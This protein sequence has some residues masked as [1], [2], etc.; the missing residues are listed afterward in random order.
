METP[1]KTSRGRPEQSFW[2]GG[3]VLVLGAVVAV[4]EVADD[5]SDCFLN[6][7]TDDPK[8]DSR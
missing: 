2:V 7:T 5:I 6:F 1:M 8:C 4:N 3:V